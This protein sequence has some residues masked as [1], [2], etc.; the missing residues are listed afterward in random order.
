MSKEKYIYIVIACLSLISCSHKNP[1]W[2]SS[3]HNSAQSFKELLPYIYGQEVFNNP[4]K[5]STIEKKLQNFSNSLH[6]IPEAQAQK[7]FGNDPLVTKGLSDLK[8]L[9]DRAYS[10]YAVGKYNYSQNILKQTSKYCFQC[11]TRVPMGPQDISWGSF[12]LS[13]YNLNSFEKAQIYV[14]MR[15]YDKAKD[16]LLTLIKQQTKERTPLIK[17]RAIKYYL[18]ISIRGQSNFNSAYTLVDQQLNNSQLSKNFRTQLKTYKKH[19]LY[20]MANFSKTNHSLENVEKILKIKNQTLPTYKEEQFVQYATAATIL[21]SL[22]NS[23]NNNKT[24]AEIYYYLG[25][26]Y[27][28]LIEGSFWEL[29]DTYYEVCVEIHPLSPIAKKCVNRLK[30]NLMIKSSGS[31]YFEIHEIE[32]YRLEKLKEKAG[33]KK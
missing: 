32:K 14:A 30:E 6:R 15:Q 5:Q 27:D 7:M 31:E 19:L 24:K 23:E 2:S 12:T 28:Y 9:A 10:Y 1:Q 13:E 8:Q 22:L 4:A 21:H 16:S 18:L 29:P 17:E 20:W 3:M 11:H 33:Y 25:H 26:I